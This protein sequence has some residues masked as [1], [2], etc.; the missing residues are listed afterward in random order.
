M[1]TNECIKESSNTI[2]D[3]EKIE[4]GTIQEKEKLKN[5]RNILSFKGRAT[6]T[7]YLLVTF[8]TNAVA[9]PANSDADMTPLFALLYFALL[10][11]MIWMY[12]S[13]LVRRCHDCGKKWWYVL[14]PLY[15]FVLYFLPGQDGENEY[16]LNPRNK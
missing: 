16:G 15:Y 8:I 3:I 11:V 9:L 5:K 14:I 13:T 6:R 4:E 2:E 7:E 12:F 10:L 1:E